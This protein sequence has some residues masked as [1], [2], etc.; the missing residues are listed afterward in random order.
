[1]IKTFWISIGLVILAYLASISNVLEILA[2][3]VTFYVA[4]ILL[5]GVL[6]TAVVVLQTYNNKRKE[7]EEDDK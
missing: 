7:N 5:V 3:R 4:L 6:M 2:H 1:M